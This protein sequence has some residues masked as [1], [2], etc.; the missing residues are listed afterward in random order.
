MEVVI[1]CPR[2]APSFAHVRGERR[3]LPVVRSPARACNAAMPCDEVA[4]RVCRILLRF[5]PWSGIWWFERVLRWHAIA[6]PFENSGERAEVI[7]KKNGNSS[8]AKR[9]RAG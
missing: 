6:T 5:A 1:L 7:F 3:L 2:Q 8:G 4:V 9:R